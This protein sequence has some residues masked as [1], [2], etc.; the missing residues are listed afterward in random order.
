MACRGV[1][2]ASRPNWKSDVSDILIKMYTKELTIDEGTA[3]DA[4]GP[5]TAQALCNV[6]GERDFMDRK[7][8][9]NEDAKWG[10]IL[11]APTIIG[12][13]VLNV[14]PF[15]ETLILSFSH[16]TSFWHL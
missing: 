2:N 4:G 6:R 14:Y 10:Y 7:K 13:L 16:H 9:L 3:G 12:L 5:W 11:I 15:I 1:N 8:F